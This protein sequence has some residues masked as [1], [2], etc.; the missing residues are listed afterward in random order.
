MEIRNQAERIDLFNFSTPQMRAFHCSWAVFFLCFFAW[1]GLAPLMPMIREEMKLEPWQIGNL[2]AA[3]VAATIL[4]RLIIGPLCEW[5]GPR[6]TYSWLLCICAIPVMCVGFAQSYESLL[7][8]RFAIS[9]IGASFVITQYHTSTMFSKNCVGAANAAA[10][11]WGNLG[12]GVT[13]QVMPL[14]VGGLMAAG[15]SSFW[16]WRGAMFFVGLACFVAGLA[17][18]YF[19]QDSPEGDFREL[20]TAGRLAR[21]K[22]SWGGFWSAC[23]DYRVWVLFAA[24]AASFGIELTMDNVAAI[25]FFDQFDLGH[26]SAGIIAGLFGAMN[27]FARFLGG[28][29]AD[30]F[31]RLGGLRARIGWLAAVLFGEGI[32]LVC[33]G[34]AHTVGV[35]IGMLLLMGLCV[36]MANGAAYAVVPLIHTG[37]L[38]AVAGIVGAGGNVGAVIA[39]FMFRAPTQD[40]PAVLQ[41]LGIGVLCCAALPLILSLWNRA[42]SPVISDVKTQEAFS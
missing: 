23:M 30:R 21:K 41:M 8:F 26:T 42:A 11:G 35:A 22:T 38:G 32:L 34:H 15:I 4:A 12:G 29:L 19:T 1:F 5:L 17:Y 3:S 13:Q 39:G 27:L 14:A 28:W 25:Y 2:I 33:F 16:A 20:R 7:L 40:W 24:Y 37:N 6:R 31:G 36:K 10:A 18:Y 9:T